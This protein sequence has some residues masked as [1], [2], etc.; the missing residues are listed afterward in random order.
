MIRLVSTLLLS[1]AALCA[2]AHAQD[3]ERHELPATKAE[4]VERAMERFAAADRDGDGYLNQEE[5]ADNLQERRKNRRAQMIDRLDTNDDGVISEAE[6]SVLAEKRFS[7]L[8]TN[9]DGVLSEDEIE[10]AKSKK[11]R[12]W[13]G[14]RG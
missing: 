12:A 5:I 6:M 14:R 2:S 13:Q 4:A 3:R 7:K 10:A 1:S 8:D 9:D 11:R